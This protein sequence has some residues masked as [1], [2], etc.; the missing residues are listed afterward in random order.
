MA[1]NRQKKYSVY[2]KDEQLA[3]DLQGIAMLYGV[4]YS[5]IVQEALKKYI[6]GLPDDDL[7]C[8]RRFAQE[9]LERQ[10]A[11]EAS[12]IATPF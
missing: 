7:E 2:F 1:T 6:A 3:K 5:D 9:R 8:A 4:S 10:Q 12:P 11:R